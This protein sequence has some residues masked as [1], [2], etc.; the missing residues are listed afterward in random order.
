MATIAVADGCNFRR[1]ILNTEEEAIIMANMEQVQLVRQGRDAVARWREEHPGEVLDLNACYMSHTRIPMVDLSGADMRNSDLMGAM[2][3]RANLSG[4]R[5]N[6]IHM[7]RADLRQAKFSESLLNGANLRGADCREADFQDADLDRIILS[8]AN[9]S[10]ANLR[11]ANLSRANLDRANLTGA[12]L[13]GATLNGAAL[14]R[15]NLSDAIFQE[16]DFYEAVFNTTPLT[17][18]NFTGSIM[19]YTVF[20]NCDLSVAQGL[21]QVRHD[22]PSTLGMDSLFRSGGGIP[23]T[24]LTGVGAPETLAAFQQ[25]LIGAAALSGDYFISCAAGDVAFAQKLQADL[26]ANGARC[27][28]FPENARGSALVDRRSSS[29][30]EEIERWIRHYDKLLVV[31]TPESFGS[32]TIRN[33]IIQAKEQQQSRD[34]WLLFLVTGDGFMA[35]SRDRY[36][37]GLNAEHRVFDLPGQAEN[38]E[39]Y[40]QGIAELVATLQQVQP[41]SAGA[42]V[43]STGGGS[44]QL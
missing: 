12:D 21:D 26:R 42:P 34:E 24:F 25:S 38:T 7:Y 37:R 33:D 2:L 17:G 10:G 23:E 13:T 30:E 27:W 14:T 41:A 9:L 3:R 39:A 4:C 43:L 36:A 29:N 1:L 20:Q 32:E 19:G 8:D 22:A 40:Q 11:G 28:L 6:P 18:A 15:T 16:S 44:M 5:L 31:C 35:S